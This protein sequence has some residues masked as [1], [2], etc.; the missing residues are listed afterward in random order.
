M[1]FT[2]PSD[3]WKRGISAVQNAV[4]SP[5]SNPMVENIFVE[6]K[7]SEVTFMATNLN[8]CIRCRSKVEIE[9]EGSIALPTKVIGEIVSDLPQNDVT[10]TVVGTSIEIVAGSFDAKLKGL[11][12]DQF[13]PFVEVE[14]GVE[15]T[16]PAK[17]LK[18]AIYMTN[19][20]TTTEK[21]RF[22]LDGLKWVVQKDGAK[23]VATDGRRLACIMMPW[24][25]SNEITCLVPSKTMREANGSL[26]DDGDVH[27]R[28]GERKMMLSGGDVEMSS[29]LLVD[30]FPPYERIIPKECLLTAVIPREEFST[31]VRRASHL[32]NTDTNLVTISMSKN[33]LTI[34]GE[35]QEVGGI[36]RDDIEI[37]YEGEE[38]KVYYNHKYI[39]DV[40]KVLDTEKIRFELWDATRPGVIRPMDSQDYLY[41]IMPMRAPDEESAKE[42]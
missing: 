9:E 2:C 32:A 40:L 14:E 24:T 13:P 39:I 20:A 28:I 11:P 4:G 16:V 36:G 30:N 17:E 19:Y 7:D 31:A 34:V 3:V 27:I 21:S 5:I 1:K 22:E 25:A 38:I 10:F 29:N 26:P 23:I 41:V 8:L 33:L 35:R 18:K 6:C 12:G 37:E 15:L 42:E